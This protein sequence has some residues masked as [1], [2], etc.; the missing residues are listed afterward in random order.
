LNYSS[1]KYATPKT[2]WT[3]D[4]WRSQS[5]RAQHCGSRALIRR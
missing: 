3:P 1:T 5:S 2:P 4:I